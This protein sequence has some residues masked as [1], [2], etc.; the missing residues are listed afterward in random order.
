MKKLDAGIVGYG[1]YISRYRVRLVDIAK[2]WGYDRSA[3]AL[4]LTEKSV[5]GED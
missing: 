2:H 3:R 5:Q 4:P 1:V